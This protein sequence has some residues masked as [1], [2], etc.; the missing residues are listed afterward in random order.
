LVTT[1]PNWCLGILS[2]YP[3]DLPT[4]FDLLDRID[5]ASLIQQRRVTV[6]FLRE[7]E[8]LR[9]DDAGIENKS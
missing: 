1:D 8:A 5:R 7:L 9:Y 3:R 4:L 6:P 2:R